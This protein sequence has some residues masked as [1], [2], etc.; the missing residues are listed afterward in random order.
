MDNIKDTSRPRVRARK[1]RIIDGDRA[2][3]VRNL[4][5]LYYREWA[6]Y[7]QVPNVFLQAR[8]TQEAR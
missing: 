3:K 4:H 1:G 2:N 6:W 8:S 5:A 7:S